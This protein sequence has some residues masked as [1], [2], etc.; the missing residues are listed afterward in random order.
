MKEW[1]RAMAVSRL[2]TSFAASP[3]LCAPANSSRS[4]RLTAAFP[5]LNF[6]HQP[7]R[8]GERGSVESDAVSDRY[9]L[10]RRPPRMF[11]TAAANVDAELLLQRRQAPLQCTDHTGGDAGRM[12]VHAHDGAETCHA[13][14]EPFRN[15]PAM[16]REVGASRPSSHKFT[17]LAV[18]VGRQITPFMLCTRV[19]ES[20]Q[21]RK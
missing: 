17:I 11:A 15:L 20:G 13:V 14:G 16:Q 3:G 21:M 1:D 5:V 2:R 12:P 10:V 9:E 18:L 7:A 6:R 4:R 19:G 8:F